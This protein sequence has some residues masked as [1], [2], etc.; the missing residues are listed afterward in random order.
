MSDRQ[1]RDRC[2][3]ERTDFYRCPIM[4]TAE[5]LPV[6]FSE[7]TRS[8]K[9]ELWKNAIR[10]EM[11]SHHENKTWTLVEKPKKKSEGTQ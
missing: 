5:K 6:N 11:K 3:V 8:E 2:A 10:D 4:Y 9:G 7:A 1:L